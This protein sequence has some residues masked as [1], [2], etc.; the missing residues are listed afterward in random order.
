M[1]CKGEFIFKSISKVEAGEFKNS[2]GDIIKF[3]SSYK[4]LLDNWRDDKV[5]E[6]KIKLNE[7]SKE[8][9]QKFKTLRPYQQIIIEF[10]VLIY[11]NQV[12]LIPVD[13]TFNS[14]NK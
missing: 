9:I 14:N 8:L 10:D 6:F 12:R 1:K 2:N 7:D 5:D 11:N 4:V 13:L 3:N